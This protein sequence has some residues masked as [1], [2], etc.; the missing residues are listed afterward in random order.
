[1]FHVYYITVLFVCLAVKEPFREAIG[2]S[3]I[4]KFL[5]LLEFDTFTSPA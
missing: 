3:C 2:V 5:L 4:L 1:M